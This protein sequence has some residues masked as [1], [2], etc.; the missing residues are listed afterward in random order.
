MRKQNRKNAFTLVELLITIGI[1]VIIA[2]IAVP[3]VVN[4]INR[5]K[6]ARAQMD[7]STI[8]TAVKCF[9][10]DWGEYPISLE[11]LKGIETGVGVENIESNYTVS[12][13]KGGIDYFGSVIPQDIFNN[14]E[15]GN[16]YKYDAEDDY[17]ILW[18]LGINKNDDFGGDGITISYSEENDK[19]T[20]ETCPE[21]YDDIYVSNKI[22]EITTGS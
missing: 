12:G 21:D 14:S 4:Y 18:S 10:T 17:Y 20:I 3:Q 22:V 16:A 5:S 6:C 13:L 8:S 2:G 11:E 7:M 1:L 15:T 9:Y 19:I